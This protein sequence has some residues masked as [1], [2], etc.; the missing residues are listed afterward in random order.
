MHNFIIENRLSA[1]VNQF[2]AAAT[3][4]RSEA[5]KRGRPVVLCRS[6]DAQLDTGKCHTAATEN[7]R[8]D[9]WGSGWLV[10][11]RDNQEVLLRQAALAD[12]TNAFAGKKSIHYNG[13]GNISATFTHVVFGHQG[14]FERT[15]CIGRS[16]R[17]NL[18]R[19]VGTC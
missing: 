9:D 11:V 12:S 10:M 18:L 15:I 4:A 14:K 8:A 16:G 5:I 2:I 19:G 7:R 13:A 6:V 3:F 17:L 1:D